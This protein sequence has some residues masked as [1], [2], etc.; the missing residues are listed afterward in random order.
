MNRADLLR[1]GRFDGPA[2]KPAKTAHKPHDGSSQ[3]RTG[4]E[5]RDR[6]TRQEEAAAA[7]YG[8]RVKP[9]SGSHPLSKGDVQTRSFLMEMK[10]TI[11]GSLSV[12]AEWLEKISREAAGEARLPALE[13]K[14]ECITDPLVEATW[15]MVPAS[16]FRQLNEEASIKKSIS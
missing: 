6:A 1:Q 15:V 9:G 2:V 4:N 14:L 12:K 5:N 3:G 16:V 13:I 11:H 7:R 10:T 8:G